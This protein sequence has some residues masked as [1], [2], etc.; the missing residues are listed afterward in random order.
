[1]NITL[2]DNGGRRQEGDRRLLVNEHY[3]PERRS[4]IDR[5]Q[6]GDRRKD[7]EALDSNRERRVIFELLS[8]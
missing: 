8:A 5:R 1:M 7:N 3:S 2:T 6:S 4:G